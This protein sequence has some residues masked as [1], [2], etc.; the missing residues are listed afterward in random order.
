MIE[1][2]AN[3]GVQIELRCKIRTAEPA[4]SNNH[5]ESDIESSNIVYSVIGFSNGDSNNESQKN[6]WE[7]WIQQRI[8]YIY[9]YNPMESL[10]GSYGTLDPTENLI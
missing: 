5:R 8:L 2:A 6:P 10:C 9:I 4:A 3:L 7:S 1:N